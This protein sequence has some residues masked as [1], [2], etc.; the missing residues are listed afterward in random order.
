MA[1]HL[2]NLKSSSSTQSYKGKSKSVTLLFFRRKLAENLLTMLL[3]LV[4]FGCYAGWHIVLD[5]TRDST[6]DNLSICSQADSLME[7]IYESID[8]AYLILATDSDVTK[9]LRELFEDEAPSLYALRFAEDLS[10]NFR[11]TIFTNPYIQNI[12]FYINN[13]YRRVLTPIS[14][15]ITVLSPDD[16]QH[17]SDALSY[18]GTDQVW[19]MVSD[20]PLLDISTR[21]EAMQIYRKLYY[22]T[23]RKQSGLIAYTI[24]MDAFSAYLSELYLY[25]NQQMIILD[26]E[27]NYFWSA[28]DAFS[29]DPELHS[30]LQLA[31]QDSSSIHSFHGQY[32]QMTLCRSE[33]DYGLSFVLMTPLSDIY[34]SVIDFMRIFLIIFAVTTGATILIAY[35]RTRA[36]NKNVDKI[37]QALS[38]PKSLQNAHNP[39]NREKDLFSYIQLNIIRLFLEQDTLKMDNLQKSAELNLSKIQA[40]QHQINPHFLNNTLNNIYWEAIKLTGGENECSNMIRLLSDFMRYSI[41]DPQE[42]VA[43]VDEIIFIEKYI[44]LMQKRFPD[45]FT[46]SYQ[47]APECENLLLKKMLLQPLVENAIYHGVKDQPTAGI[48]EIR[49]LIEGGLACISVYDNGRGMA[50]E[51]VATLNQQ[52]TSG[53]FPKASNSSEHIGMTNTNRRLL[54]SFGPESHLWVE[55]TPG[56]YTKVRFYL[57]LSSNE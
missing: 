32:Y 37:L 39:F 46:F 16:F 24:N 6:R 13:P 4:L 1:R 34:R 19:C 48:I 17:I 55:S 9:E 45:R 21:N 5:C 7:S 31:L 28:D 10:V 3:P 25:D 12:Y 42:D 47:I 8:N 2:L 11:N 20:A 51:M 29:N 33:R 57:P 43:L 44:A 27:G 50:E 52:F 23:T 49:A 30:L 56:Q 22:R 18:Q 36:E 38:D 35:Y 54:L 41:S 15:K 14:K 40:L 26:S 53:E